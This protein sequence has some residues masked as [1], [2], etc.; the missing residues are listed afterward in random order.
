[1]YYLFVHDDATTDLVAIRE[2]DKQTAASILIQLQELKS[3]Q[4]L[5]DRLTQHN[6]GAD[7]TADFHVSRFVEQWNQGKNL[8]RLKYWNLGFE[9]KHYRIVYA[10]IPLGQVIHVF[11]LAHV[12]QLG[13]HSIQLDRLSKNPELQV[14]IGMVPL[15]YPETHYVQ[16]I[17]EV[18]H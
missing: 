12:L 13:K 10:F 18:L 2:T 8:W 15:S 14:H 5:M 1:M 9:T 3:N 4:D 16:W 11:L 17:E 7:E 6:Y